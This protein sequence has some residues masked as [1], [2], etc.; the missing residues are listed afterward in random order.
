[1]CLD[2]FFLA[3]VVNA[4]ER[5]QRA[6]VVAEILDAVRD[7]AVLEEKR[8][9]M[10]EPCQKNCALIERSYVE[11]VRDE[12]AAICSGDQLVDRLCSAGQLQTG[13]VA[14]ESTTTAASW[15]HALLCC[16]EA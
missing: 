16:P 11:E 14:T 5:Q 15:F 1:S 9:V 6:V 13:R 10:C 8:A 3:D 7:L 12:N 4:R 2:W